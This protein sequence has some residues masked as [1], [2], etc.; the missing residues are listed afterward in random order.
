VGHATDCR[1]AVGIGQCGGHIG[2]EKDRGDGHMAES[3]AG[4]L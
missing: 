2:D 1:F 3:N 4:L